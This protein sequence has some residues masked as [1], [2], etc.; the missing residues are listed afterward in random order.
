MASFASF[1]Y[2]ISQGDTSEKV[3]QRIRW[4]ESSLIAEIGQ[5]V[6]TLTRVVERGFDTLKLETAMAA[7]KA[8]MNL[9]Y[10]Y[11]DL[12]LEE[13][14]VEADGYSS[15]AVALLLQQ[16]E[17]FFLGGLIAAGNVRIDVIRALDPDFASD[18]YR[19][20]EINTLV[21]AVDAMLAKVEQAVLRC[22]KVAETK[23]TISLDPRR[24]AYS[25]AVRQM[26]YTSKGPTPSSRFPFQCYGLL[27]PTLCPEL[28][29]QDEARQLADNALKNGIQ[30]HRRSLALP[31]QHGIVDSWRGLIARQQLASV[32]T[33]VLG[34]TPTPF[35]LQRAARPYFAVETKSMPPSTAATKS[36]INTNPAL[37]TH[38]D[39][40]P[41]LVDLL[42][43]IEFR[44]KVLGDRDSEAAYEELF[45][46]IFDRSPNQN[47]KTVL[48][49]IEKEL[50][51]EGLVAG[52]IYGKQYAEEC[53]TGVPASRRA[54]ARR[55]QAHKPA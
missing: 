16:S 55:G 20:E 52:L 12:G 13:A 44:K 54:K 43:S 4:L 38:T 26:S 3:L 48:A 47:E 41:F 5:A 8:A 27:C 17:V 42:T 25:A 1:L 18:A 23:F 29:T 22:H 6:N 50:G 35:H 40:R 2:D 37:H 9:L 21:N 51:F 10:S 33:R 39:A 14:L 45:N 7:S 15:N 49:Q 46:R 53:G 36:D 31:E 34:Y 28:Y 11:R 24:P 19:M 32:V 30:A